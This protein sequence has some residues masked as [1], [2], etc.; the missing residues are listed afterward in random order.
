MSIDFVYRG[1]PVEQAGVVV[2]V[3]PIHGIVALDGLTYP[4]VLSYDAD[5]NAFTYNQVPSDY[6]PAPIVRYRL[7]DANGL[8]LIDGAGYNIMVRG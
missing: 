4:G 8:A 5:G 2:A 6:N 1:L 7:I 3:Q